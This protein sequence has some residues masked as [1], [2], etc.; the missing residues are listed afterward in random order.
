M[1]GFVCLNFDDV[2]VQW[3]VQM[4]LSDVKNSE[5]ANSIGGGG[6]G[7]GGEKKTPTIFFF[8]SAFV[9]LSSEVS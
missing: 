6:G 9:R 4:Q 5:I 3:L 2:F 7:K 8:K 1:H